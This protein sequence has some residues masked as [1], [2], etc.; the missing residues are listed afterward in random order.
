MV[1][2]YNLTYKTCPTTE[3][4][5]N[6]DKTGSGKTWVLGS[7][8]DSDRGHAGA[9]EGCPLNYGHNT[10]F[11]T[12]NKE[13]GIQPGELDWRT[14]IPNWG[15]WNDSMG[16]SQFVLNK[17]GICSYDSNIC[18]LDASTLIGNNGNAGDFL[19]HRYRIPNIYG[20]DDWSVHGIDSSNEAPY[21]S[22][23]GTINN[24][25][26]EIIS[27]DDRRMYAYNYNSPIWYRTGLQN[28]SEDKL[29]TGND[30]TWPENTV[31]RMK[32][33]TDSP[34][35]PIGNKLSFDQHAEAEENSSISL[36]SGRY[37]AVCMKY[38][39][40]YLKTRPTDGHPWNREPYGN[41]LSTPEL[42]NYVGVSEEDKCFFP[43]NW[44]EKPNYELTGKGLCIDINDETEC[45][46]MPGCSYDGAACTVDV[47]TTS[48]DAKSNCMTNPRCGGY[49]KREDGNF[50]IREGIALIPSPS[51][52]INSMI[53]GE[54]KEDGCKK[55]HTKLCCGIKKQ[56]VYPK[57]SIYYQDNTIDIP[58]EYCHPNYCSDHS[59]MSKKCREE[60][61]NWCRTED[62]FTDD[63]CVPPETYGLSMFV[64]EIRRQ[65]GVGFSKKILDTRSRSI[66]WK[67]YSI[68]GKDYCTPTQDVFTTSDI[69]MDEQKANF[70]D[71]WP[72]KK[73]KLI[74]PN[75]EL[76]M[77]DDNIN[78]YL[79]K[80]INN[81]SNPSRGNFNTEINNYK[82]SLNSEYTLVPSMC[83]PQEDIDGDPIS[84]QRSSCS[85]LINGPR[86]TSGGT[87][88]FPW[89]SLDGS[90]R[91]RI[92][93]EGDRSDSESETGCMYFP[94][95]TYKDIDG[96]GAL[97]HLPP[98]PTGDQV[99]STTPSFIT[100]W[101]HNFQI[102]NVVN[103]EL[104][105]NSN[106]ERIND[107][108][109]KAIQLGATNDEIDEI[110]SNEAYLEGVDPDYKP[111]CQMFPEFE[112]YNY[113]NERNNWLGGGR[114]SNDQLAYSEGAGE[115][116][117]KIINIPS[118]PAGHNIPW[119]S[120]PWQFTKQTF[121]DF[122][123]K[124]YGELSCIAGWCNDLTECSSTFSLMDCNDKRPSS[125]T[126]DT[127]GSGRPCEY[128]IPDG[129]GAYDLEIPNIC[130]SN[131]VTVTPIPGTDAEDLP[132]PSNGVEAAQNWVDSMVGEGEITLSNTTAEE[133]AEYIWESNSINPLW[134]GPR[135]NHCI[136]PNS[137]DI[138]ALENII[139]E[140]IK[141]KQD[142]KYLSCTRWCKNN[143][144]YCNEVITDHC[145]K[146]YYGE[147]TY[148][149]GSINDLKNYYI[150]TLSEYNL[151]EI[152]NQARIEGITESQINDTKREINS[153]NITR[154]QS[155]MP[156]FT[157]DEKI[158]KYLEL[159][160]INKLRKDN[161]DLCACNWPD[162]F[163]E[164][165]RDNL[166]DFYN[167]P[168]YRLPQNRKCIYKKC[169]SAEIR[170]AGE[171]Y[172]E[173]CPKESIV[174]CI[175]RM[176]IQFGLPGSKQDLREQ[177]D[178]SNINIEQT[179]DCDLDLGNN[180]VSNCYDHREDCSTLSNYPGCD[181]TTPIN[182]AGNVTYISNLCP[183]S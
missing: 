119:G 114:Q 63:N 80:V 183:F 134:R 174:H 84:Y 61:T 181:S 12:D 43:D 48:G 23:D 148:N 7:F 122:I 55:L 135:K 69:K 146:I 100:N 136:G 72:P 156:P 21:F 42:E 141:G 86:D 79:D 49:I 75:G 56:V 147:G 30:Y 27:E 64:D 115:E 161:E 143:T 97:I 5:K 151:E 3:E 137:T 110:L 33:N 99:Q 52:Q 153:E 106:I 96:G 113:I 44:V 102:A 157:Q 53:K 170:H 90:D 8:N 176:D 124:E 149:E 164:N 17:L 59:N 50:E 101:F 54:I 158:S 111:E 66:D 182:E 11:H 169:E 178:L 177:L 127:T 120:I 108:R 132:T 160:N 85:N 34:L 37:A 67:D 60:L 180:R 142:K 58:N 74:N 83:I 133:L 20:G 18:S 31:E 41:N 105:N 166:Q 91:E 28:C 51:S 24:V 32:A 39:D 46:R 171:E 162:E 112:V 123:N 15:F 121:K 76:L 155:M 9:L 2:N 6:I 163:Y 167:V 140:L 179:Q 77:R 70:L 89:E 36:D 165:I 104:N 150:N 57:D 154:I 45:T 73:N 40:S 130:F 145:K 81:I 16:K 144:R 65:Q 109:E 118:P 95:I 29:C 126:W 172:L 139:L 82:D 94:W 116:M 13:M 87:I 71:E 159:I 138:N 92:A 4:R 19:D 88:D 128:N 125:G 173:N 62:N 131:Y 152:I 14:S 35:I 78:T 175:Q 22:T 38:N 1:R 10:I 68:I 25:E 93:C 168:Y 107:L 98:L 103:N 129:R 117:T 26:M 47:T